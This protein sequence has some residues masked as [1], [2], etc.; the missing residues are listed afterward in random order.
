MRTVNW[1]EM[2]SH[3]WEVEH[4]KSAHFW[5]GTGMKDQNGVEIFEGDILQNRGATG[6]DFRMVVCFGRYPQPN[7]D[8]DGLG[9]YVR[10]SKARNRI[11]RQDF[12]YW[13][14]RSRVIGNIHENPEL[15]EEADDGGDCDTCI[16][17]KV[18]ELWRSAEC[19]DASCFFRDGCGLYREDAE[20][21]KHGHWIMYAYDE[22]ICSECGYD[23]GTE[24]ESTKE[25]K[26]RWDELPMWCEGCGAK[27]DRETK[28]EGEP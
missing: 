13:A 19:Q 5:L 21:S 15:M 4:P 26:E 12:I 11:W 23:R 7:T 3:G 8:G 1:R 16:H 6:R 9:F 18:C 25:A 17:A 28:E 27:M 20:P 14:D 22:A 2:T 24:F 10:H